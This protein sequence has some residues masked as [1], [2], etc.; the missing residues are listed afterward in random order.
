MT[1]MNGRWDDQFKEGMGKRCRDGGRGEG[2]QARLVVQPSAGR[3]SATTKETLKDK[4]IGGTIN[5][6]FNQGLLL[7]QVRAA[8]KRV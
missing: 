7:W 3:Q 4:E 2:M 8:H 6:R 1:S 5:P